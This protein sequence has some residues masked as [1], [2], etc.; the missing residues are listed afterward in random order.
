MASTYNETNG[1]VNVQGLDL[2]QDFYV[3]QGLQRAKVN[4]SNLVDPSFAAAAVAT[5]G[6]Y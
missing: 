5:L 1:E 4:L 6:R 2:D 3:A